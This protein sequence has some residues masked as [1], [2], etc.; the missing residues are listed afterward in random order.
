MR[1]LLDSDSNPRQTHIANSASRCGSIPAKNPLRFSEAASP[2]APAPS[3][4]ACSSFRTSTSSTVIVS[5]VGALS[6]HCPHHP[7][8]QAHIGRQISMGM[9]RPASGSYLSHYPIRDSSLTV[10][11][12]CEQAEA[13]AASVPTPISSNP[14]SKR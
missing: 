14:S 2:H 12:S 1:N 3:N 5:T 6:R 9:L 8:T 10:N 11:P 13:A 4:Q 7:K